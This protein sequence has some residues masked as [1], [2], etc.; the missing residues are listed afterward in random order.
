MKGCTLV[1]T[2]KVKYIPSIENLPLPYSILIN[3]QY[4]SFL[5]KL[6]C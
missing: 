6:I 1:N 4:L 3:H 2:V 5:D